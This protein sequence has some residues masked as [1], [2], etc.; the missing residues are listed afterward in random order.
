VPQG[1]PPQPNQGNRQAFPLVSPVS[2]PIVAR[3]IV[4]INLSIGRFMVILVFSKGPFVLTSPD[5]PCQSVG[6]PNQAAP[7]EA[8][9]LVDASDCRL[10]L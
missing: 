4:A 7:N 1:E 3:T 8:Q 5:L 2:T 6:R 10:F 9:T